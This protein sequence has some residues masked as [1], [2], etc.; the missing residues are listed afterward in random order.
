MSENIARIISEISIEAG[1]RLMRHTPQLY[2]KYGSTPPVRI[3]PWASGVLI[4]V[5]K[6]F[7]LVTAA[8][9]LR[10]GNG[11][12]NPE[13]IGIMTGNQFNILNGSIKIAHPS[14]H[15]NNDKVDLAIWRIEDGRVIDELKTKYDF[16]STNQLGIDHSPVEFSKYLVVGFPITRTKLKTQTSKIIANPFIFLTKKS[17]QS[18]Y[19]KLEFES[20]SNLILNYRKRK[21]KDS[22]GN[23]IQG[24]DP[25]GIS[26]WGLWYLPELKMGVTPILV[27]IM[28]EWRSS[29]AAIVATRI[30]IVTE[31]LRTEFG[32]PLQK[33]AIT[34]VNLYPN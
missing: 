33:S 34:K 20:H 14:L 9:V 3:E 32:L 18:I 25:Y 22:N 7:F 1:G 23:V 30:H 26:G 15:V 16:L 5:D 12:I 8:H 13:D 19:D 28:T 10:E 29:L 24:P 21:I 31:V 2:R 27:G 11:D 6:I 4:E 17:K